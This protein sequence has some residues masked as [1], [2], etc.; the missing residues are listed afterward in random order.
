MHALQAL[1]ET[2]VSLPPS[3]LEPFALPEPLLDAIELARRIHSHEGRRRQMQLIGK[4][5]RDIDPEPIRDALAHD[6]RA[7]REEVAV[8]HAAEHW[9]DK[10]LADPSL[11]ATLPLA[12]L[13]SGKDTG[14]PDWA[15]LI[16]AAR[17]ER[18][19]GQP[20]R[21]YRELYRA[22]REWLSQPTEAP[23][24]GSQTPTR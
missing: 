16:K 10:L 23:A 3:R 1:G 18:E 6:G 21:R 15:M 14:A 11:L 20:G 19:S 13:N 12:D 5:M 7:H 17:A 24:P 2:L 4:L 22:L 8:M 9:R